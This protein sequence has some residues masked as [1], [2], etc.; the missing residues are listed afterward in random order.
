[1]KKNTAGAATIQKKPR[2]TAINLVRVFVI[3]LVI[4]THIAASN[5]LYNSYFSGAVW[6]VSH[7][8]RFLFIALTALVLLYNYP[9]S[10]SFDIKKFYLKRFPL[11]VIPY[12]TWTLIFQIQNGIQ[13]QTV[14]EFI[15]VFVS[16]FVTANAMYHLYFLVVTMQLYLLFPLVRYAYGTLR[17]TPW[18]LFG[19]S[20]G[21]QLIITALMQYYPTIPGLSW[22][23]KNPANYVWS[24][25]FFIVCGLLIATNIESIRRFLLANFKKIALSAAG[26]TVLGLVFYQLQ[27]MA[28]VTA[29]VAA[30]VFQ[31][32]IIIASITY[33]LFI[34]ALGFR[35]VDHGERFSKP[36]A[37][38]AED[39]F[40]I[41]LSHAL[42]LTIY[43]KIL[44][45]P[46][47][48]VLTG[49]IIMS[50]G[51]PL[52]YVTSFLLSEVA[53]RTPLSVF[54]IGRH[55]V[56]LKSLS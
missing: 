22:W 29:E 34:F 42:I 12:A 54:L 19:I 56:P 45:P 25:Q 40:G 24:Y 52:V 17:H 3:S 14:W 16:N 27:T 28:G 30:A 9:P 7:V 18:K 44:Q 32:Y 5:D 8:S 26:L 50:I 51:L 15:Q 1:M 13:Q 39:S 37:T 53:R 11:V 4:A 38:I 41:Y 21:V 35:W 20:L 49:L 47:N 36:I 2:I 6:T 55:R 10:Q 46:Q 31:P 43:A 48:D 33:G 23:L